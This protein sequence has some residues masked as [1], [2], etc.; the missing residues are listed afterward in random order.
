MH[1]LGG[2]NLGELVTCRHGSTW[3]LRQ[4]PWGSGT[5]GNAC[6]TT[7]CIIRGASGQDLEQDRSRRQAL[8]CI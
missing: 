4:E 1:H 8:C 2:G 3:G 7:G 6:S 5:W